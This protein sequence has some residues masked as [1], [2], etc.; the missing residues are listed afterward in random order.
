MS[1]TGDLKWLL[2][3]RVQPETRDVT[4][5]VAE[6]ARGEQALALAPGQFCMLA[7]VGG[8]DSDIHQRRSGSKRP[9]QLHDSRCGELQL[10]IGVQA[11]RRCNLDAR[12]ARPPMAAGRSGGR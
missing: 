3:R 9:A 6:P 10:R 11:S 2:I 12:T 8:R 7:A 1:P 5:I 4:T